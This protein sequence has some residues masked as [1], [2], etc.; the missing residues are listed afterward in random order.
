MVL[1]TRISAGSLFIK[2]SNGIY[3]DLL[4]RFDCE[5]CIWKPMK[6]KFFLFLQ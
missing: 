2:R 4:K 1:G 5:R 6:L 3:W